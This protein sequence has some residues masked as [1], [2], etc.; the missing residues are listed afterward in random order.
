MPVFAPFFDIL[1]KIKTSVKFAKNSQ[2]AEV[3]K[4]KFSLGYMWRCLISMQKAS[5]T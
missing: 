5:N 1:K 4:G 3:P 2:N